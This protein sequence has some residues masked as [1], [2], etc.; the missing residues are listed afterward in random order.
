MRKALKEEKDQLIC[1]SANLEGVNSLFKLALCTHNTEV[2][3]N[4][5][6]L[7]GPAACQQNCSRIVCLSMEREE[8]RAANNHEIFSF[9][10]IAAN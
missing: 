3:T 6:V 8:G 10:S 1:L 4:I 9:A 7:L 2:S 5:I